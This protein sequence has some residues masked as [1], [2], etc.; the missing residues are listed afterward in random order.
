MKRSLLS[1]LCLIG[2]LLFLI[3]CGSP[4]IGPD[5]AL[6]ER[7][8]AGIHLVKNVP[9]F[10]QQ[11]H[12][13]GPA[14]LAGLLT[15]YGYPTT[16]HEIAQAI[17]L[18]RHF[19][20]LSMDLL[21]YSK[22]KGLDTQVIEGT[23]DLLKS[24]IDQRHPIVVFL[25]LGLKIFPKGHFIIVIGYNDLDQTIIAHSGQEAELPIPYARFLPAWEKTG[26]WTLLVNP[27]RPA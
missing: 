3:G 1:S 4:T 16:Q 8:K 6:L 27:K 14:A 25:N 7:P 2:S 24:E 13:C 5:Q 17:Y 11:D 22:A 15:Y 21:L 19:G 18:P 12:Y 9:F 20:T 26:F 23:L 10:P